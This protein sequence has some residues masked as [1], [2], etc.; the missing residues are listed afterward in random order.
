MS[1]DEVAKL[2]GYDY[3]KKTIFKELEEASPADLYSKYESMNT[4]DLEK[5]LFENTN[6]IEC[7]LNQYFLCKL[8]RESSIQ[9]KKNS[10]Q[11]IS[12]IMMMRHNKGH[13]TNIR[14]RDI[15]HMDNIIDEYLSLDM[16]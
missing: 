1:F 14:S 12:R 9:R 16:I 5:A 2:F 7:V 15:N 6:F 4:W 3:C 10:V 13:R 11:A 8:A